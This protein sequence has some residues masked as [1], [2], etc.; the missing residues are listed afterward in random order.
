LT[1]DASPQLDW[2]RGEH[3]SL[4]GSDP[5]GVWMAPGRVNVIGEHTDYNNGFVLPF[6]LENAVLVAA[7][8]R[9]DETFVVSSRQLGTSSFDLDDL[10]R[11]TGRLS[12]AESA[13][14]AAR[15]ECRGLVGM[16]LV[17]DSSIPIGS[18]L[19]SSAAFVSALILAASEVTGHSLSPET[20][21]RAARRAESEGVGVPVGVMDPMVSMCAK[22]EH[23]LFLDCQTLDIEHIPFRVSM[24][25]SSAVIVIDTRTPRRLV[26][27]EYAD[28]RRACHDAAV[29]LGVGSLRDA[30]LAMLEGNR[31]RLSD[32]EFHR[33]RHVVTEN[34]RVVAAV[35]AMREH[36]FEALGKLLSESHRSL[37]DDFEV[38]IP[39]LDVAAEAAVDAGAYGARM[40]GAG[41]G[42]CAIALVPA[43]RTRR[44][45][46]AVTS[47][48]RERDLGPPGFLP[49]RPSPGAQRID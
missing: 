8:L 48:F 6:A 5:Q 41:F 13:I 7:S 37:A 31:E 14:Q 23:A 19:S 47:A 30:S 4:H 1:V 22:A 20:I 2:V 12:H 39:E 43:D 21:A 9:N 28:R 15:E 45:E 25:D 42:G 38:S 18:G 36:R 24:G 46:E 16:N 17:V 3:L 40:T 34:S 32:E 33:A 29:A 11:A 49:A 10:A 26:G 27:G 44:V 35:E